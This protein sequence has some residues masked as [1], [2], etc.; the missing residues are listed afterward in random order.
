ME[1]ALFRFS[2]TE[3]KSKVF[4]TAI[5]SVLTSSLIFIFFMTLF[6]EPISG[7]IKFDGHPEYVTWFSII[8][9]ADAV[10]AI[11]FAKLREM[12]KP[13]RFAFLKTLNLAINISLN[14]FFILFCKRI[15]EGGDSVFKPFVNSIYNPNIGVGYI[16]IFILISNLATLL[17]LLPEIFKFKL[18]FDKEL[19]KKMLRYSAPLIIAGLAGMA[20]DTLDRVLLTWIVPGKEGLKQVGI[21]TS[22]YKVSIIMVLFI[23]TFRFAAEPF[24][25][26]QFKEKIQ[27]KCMQI[28]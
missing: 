14:L 27:K 15:Y 17:F 22:C 24:F 1:T 4:T 21:Y 12:G 11:A 6:S 13:K 28:L 18:E 8:L 23:Q 16:F 10:S 2:Q 3:D 5:I 25:F 19:W 26:S 7:Y 20:N 9:G